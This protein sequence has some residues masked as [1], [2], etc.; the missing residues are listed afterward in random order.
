MFSG[1]RDPDKVIGLGWIDTA[2]RLDGYDLS[3]ST[4]FPFDM[5]LSAHEIAHNLGALHDDDEPC[6]TDATDLGTNVM[7]SELSG[8]TR[9]EFSSCSLQRMRSKL[10]SYCLTDNIDLSISLVARPTDRAGELEIEVTAANSDSVRTASGIS[11]RT[12]FPTGTRLQSVAAG[13]SVLD[14]ILLC[15]Y[16][17][18][19]A[20]TQQSVTAVAVFNGTDEQ[21]I[22]AE[23]DTGNLVDSAQLDNRASI[24]ISPFDD[25]PVYLNAGRANEDI[26]TDSTSTATT[27]VAIAGGSAGGGSGSL[28]LLLLLGGMWVQ[29]KMDR[30]SAARATQ[31]PATHVKDRI[32]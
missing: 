28:T 22:I 20:S 19:N 16:S 6:V 11:I 5:L 25:D 18:I 27:T 29:R 14:N 12:V 2:C 1:H 8:Q 9:P 17:P 32:A 30:Q 3:M 13:C 21:Q 26:T 10:G 23:I 15:Q 31:S 7:W 4:P 24:R